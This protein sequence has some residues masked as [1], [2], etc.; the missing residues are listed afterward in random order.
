VRSRPQTLQERLMP[1]AQFE[2]LERRQQ[3]RRDRCVD[4]N[5]MTVDDD[6]D[7]DDDAEDPGDPEGEPALLK[8]R[9][10]ETTVDMFKRVLLF[11]QG[12]V[13]VLFDNQMITSLDIAKTSPTTSSRRSAVPSGSQEGT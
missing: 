13:E 4:S 10:R 7:N 2:A 9:I 1:C 3:V 5:K 6:N 11:S 12:M 8:T